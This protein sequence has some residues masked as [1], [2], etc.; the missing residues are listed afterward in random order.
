MLF[1]SITQILLARSALLCAAGVPIQTPPL[2]VK[3]SL[4]STGFFDSID[5]MD[6]RLQTPSLTLLMNY[7]SVMLWSRDSFRNATLLGDV[8]ADYV[9]LGRTVV[10]AY[11]TFYR[12]FSIGG[13]LRDSNYL[14]F[15]TA[16]VYYGTSLQYLVAVNRSHPLLNGVNSFDGK[17]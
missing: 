5:T 14:P 7:D 16:T 11:G 2:D 17:F 9:D 6:C 12:N 3:Q 13:R 10:A 1:M 4:N 15:T 8:L